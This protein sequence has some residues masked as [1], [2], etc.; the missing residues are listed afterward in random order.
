MIPLTISLISSVIVNILLVWYAR[1]LTGQFLF[2]SESIAGL[3]ESLRE[4]GTHLNGVHEM[5]MFYGDDTLGALIAHS[6][7]IVETVKEFNDSFAVETAEEEE[8]G[9]P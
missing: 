6:K 8:D 7:D 1:R 4:F 9:T 5:E 2:F 3:E